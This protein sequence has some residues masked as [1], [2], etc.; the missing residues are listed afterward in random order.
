[1]TSGR[2]LV[3]VERAATAPSPRPDTIVVVLDTA[4]TP[5]PGDRADVISI[6]PAVSDVLAREDL[7][8]EALARLDDWA[9]RTGMPDRMMDDGVSWWFRARET[10]WHWLHERILWRRAIGRLVD[11]HHVDASA[12]VAP[13]IET[14]LGDVV[15]LLGGLVVVD[16]PSAEPA[17]ERPPTDLVRRARAT[18]ARLRN[19]PVRTP[20]QVHDPTADRVR[21]LDRRV[22]ALAAAGDDGAVLVLSHMGIRQA[23]GDSAD[24]RHEDPNLGG[25]IS[26]LEAAGRPPIVM[27]LGLD[28]RKDEDWVA[29]T[30]HPRLLPASLLKSRWSRE[31]AATSAPPDT[32]MLDPDARIEAMT[33]SLDAVPPV[34]LDID[35]I[36][37][38]PALLAE[39]RAFA[40]TVVPV[41]LRQQPRITR[42]LAELRV[43]AVVLTHE[44]IRTPWLVA[45]RREGIPTI[46]VQHGVIY[47][48]HPGYAHPRHPGI[49]L[50]TKTFVFG[51]AE[52]D[53]LL[54]HGGYR[55]DE[56]VVAG[57]PRLDLDSA[58]AAVGADRSGDRAAVRSE[59]AVED[60]HRVVVIS[61]VNTPFV[62]RF[63]MVQML[64]RLLDGP[65]PRVHI[66]IK[67]HPGELD[68][69]PYRVL[70]EN[71]ARAR[72]AAPLPM[73]IVRD[74]DLYRLLRAAD[75]HLGLR[76]TVLSDAVVVGVPNLL[77]DVQAHADLLGYVE[78]G[79]ARPVRGVED[80]RAALDDPQPTDPSARAAFLDRHYRPGDASERIARAVLRAS[81]GDVRPTEAKRVEPVS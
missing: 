38:A 23:I 14:A 16:G 79:V 26:R 66:V 54:G 43:R 19:R 33:K 18:I 80:L 6:R 49:E 65:L 1:M 67:Q 47:P 30:S 4:W 78:A 35:G 70:L 28:H 69:G 9:M 77:A 20:I 34:P 52:R 44:G 3:F 71:L 27:G 17:K 24:G 5:Q 53:V 29:V 37:L 72:R 7:F 41:A 68:E 2:S 58:I 81:G 57:S 31:M 48:T 74:I 60:G 13:A 21:A 10:Q 12:M 32:D 59:L 50:P 22:A 64:E 62:R 76:S 46:A 51:E 75:A 45:A 11:E 55:D 15:R 40:R 8:D 73:S 56:V 25:V 63:H 61:G 42:M 39:L 36:D